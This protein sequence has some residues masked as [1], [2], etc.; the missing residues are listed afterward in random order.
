MTMLI[1]I[2]S[3]FEQL[4]DEILLW[5]CRYLSSTDIFYSFYGLN[6]R[7]SRTINGFCQHVVVGQVPFQRFDYICQSILPK[8]GMNI[9]SLVVS[10]DW[11]GVLSQ[12]FLN[13]FGDKMSFEFPH[14]RRLILT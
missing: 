11:K 12:R 3:H 2:K 6:Y 10:N 7:L 4:P 8:I 9:Y 5:I 14:L 1:S 13:Y